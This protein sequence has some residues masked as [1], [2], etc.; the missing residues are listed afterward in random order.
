M[1]KIKNCIFI[2]IGIFLL[3]M[4][5]PVKAQGYNETVRALNQSRIDLQE[6]IDAGFNVL[7]INDTLNEA[8]QLFEAQYALMKT[9]GT[10]DFSLI[11]ERTNEITD[12]RKQAEEMNDELKALEER[13]KE[14][15][16]ES[17]THAI[18]N[19]AKE[20]FTDERYDMVTELVEEAYGKIS[21]EQALQT[22]FKA[23]YV[24]STKTIFDFF[25]KRWKD[26]ISTIIFIILIYFFTHKRI[27]I[28]FINRKINNLNFEKEVLG[29]LIKKAQYEYFHLRKI[30]EELYHIRIGK[31]G[32][33][34]RDVDRKIPLLL[35]EKE[36]IRGIAEKEKEKAK[37]EKTKKLDKKLIKIIVISV[38]SLLIAGIFSSIYFKLISYNKI[39]EF[40]QNLGFKITQGLNFIIGTF[41]FIALFIAGIIILAILSAVFVFIYLRKK[42]KKEK[43]EIEKEKRFRFLQ[44]L[45]IFISNKIDRLKIYIKSLIERIKHAWRYRELLKQ[46]KEEE[47]P[48]IRYLRKQRTI[49]FKTNS[50][51]KIH[52]IFHPSFEKKEE[53]KPEERGKKQL[54]IENL[55]EEKQKSIELREEKKKVRMKKIFDSQHAS[56]IVRTEKELEKKKKQEEPEEKKVESTETPSSPQPKEKKKAKKTKKKRSRRKKEK[57]I[58]EEKTERKKSPK[59]KRKA[60]KEKS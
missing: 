47:K 12:L 33:L 23:I 45:Q 60:R 54:Q 2:V 35:E 48:R 11:L 8:E 15:E 5:V 31:F 18:F 16:S 49:L 27:A 51:Q 17:E 22:R 38:S 3:I 42:R 9:E 57:K 36:K 24:A 52:S 29:K 41:S 53:E 6:M 32:Q 14:I 4:S 59:R 21:E 20:E 50:Q 55:F 26:I 37:A 1:G 34:I 43:P 25:K 56:K 30:P 44:H 19:K 7:R 13:L 10:P 39:L 46:K 28:F 40:I 58:K